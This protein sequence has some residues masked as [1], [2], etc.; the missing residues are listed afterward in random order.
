[1]RSWDF[2][3]VIR[4][5]LDFPQYTFSMN[6]LGQLEDDLFDSTSD[7]QNPRGLSAGEEDPRRGERAGVL[8]CTVLY[9][10]VLYCTVLYCR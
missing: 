4:C 8:Y 5:I 6:T 10:T 7:H 3:M 2:Y 1:M 9:C